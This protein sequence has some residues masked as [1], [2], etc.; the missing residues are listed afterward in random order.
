MEIYYFFPV[1]SNVEN[2]GE[3]GA[4]DGHEDINGKEK[5][6][7]HAGIIYN[8]GNEDLM[9]NGMSRDGMD[10]GKKS[11]SSFKNKAE[12]ALV[13]KSFKNISK[14]IKTA[15]SRRKSLKR[16][17]T[18]DTLIFATFKPSTSTPSSI[19]SSSTPHPPPSPSSSSLSS[20]SSSISL[21]NSSEYQMFDVAKRSEIESKYIYNN[22]VE[23]SGGGVLSGQS[24]MKNRIS[25]FA[26]EEEVYDEDGDDDDGEEDGDEDDSGMES[27]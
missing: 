1:S 4:Y 7:N 10:V 6:E 22:G 15:T 21:S 5:D 27:D 2:K 23:K 14:D 20:Y 9:K 13:R 18:K 26:D 16:S 3:K 19:S 24:G 17:R 11:K 25:V 12:K 8:N